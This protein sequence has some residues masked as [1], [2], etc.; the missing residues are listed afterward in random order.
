[1]IDHMVNYLSD[2]LIAQV[3]DETKVGM[4]RAGLLQADPTDGII[5]ILIHPA[6]EKK[7]DARNVVERDEPYGAIIS[8]MGDGGI[9]Y[10]RRYFNIEL[11]MN[12]DGETSVMLLGNGR[13]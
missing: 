10:W 9:R 1:M 6:R 4:L 5:N 12:F 2:L 13:W 11:I 8:E 7:P 3:T